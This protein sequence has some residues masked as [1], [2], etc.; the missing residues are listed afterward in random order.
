MDYCK[1]IDKN[2]NAVVEYTYDSW[3]K[4]VAV[5]GSL[6]TTLG[7]NQPFRYRG[8]VYDNETGWYY[9]QSRYY[10]P[11]TCRFISA[12]VLLSTGQGVIGHNSFAYCNNNPLL[13]TDSEGSL[14]YQAAIHLL[15][16]EHIITNNPGVIAC[17]ELTIDRNR[18]GFGNIGWIDLID[19]RGGIY[20]IKPPKYHR[21]AIKQLDV[22]R[23]S[24]TYYDDPKYSKP[25]SIG[26][27]SFSGNFVA[28][29]SDGSYEVNY[30][31]ENGVVLYD[32]TK[33]TTP[34]PVGVYV[35]EEGLLERVRYKK[36]ART[37]VQLVYE[38]V[39]YGIVMYA[40]SSGLPSMG[41]AMSKAYG[42]FCLA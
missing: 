15:V 36:P 26:R 30:H 24:N 33:N 6:A 8:Y 32:Y 1:L 10:D 9:L 7:A 20:K 11:T 38:A 4:P 34:D 29:L 37:S 42:C 13:L 23:Y 22:Y 12:D 17:L 27:E 40:T 39:A 35:P 28:Q 25:F 41:P 5:T 21:Q 16:A 14:P 2:K 18:F 19:Y 31:T 3:G